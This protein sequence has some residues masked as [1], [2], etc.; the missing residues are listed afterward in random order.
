MVAGTSDFG[1][2]ATS[3]P[4]MTTLDYNS[5]A[6]G[7]EA[8]RLLIDLVRGKTPAQPRRI[9]PVSLIERAS[10]AR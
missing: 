2:G 7:R 6:H 1:L 4:P 10:T 5:D 3:T 8:A 9:I